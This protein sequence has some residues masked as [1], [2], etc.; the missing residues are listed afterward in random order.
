[1]HTLTLNTIVIF[2]QAKA[3]YFDKSLSSKEKYR[4]WWMILNR[5]NLIKV[6]M[7]Y[8]LRWFH[9]ICQ[10]S[11]VLLSFLY[12]RSPLKFFSWF[13]QYFS[14]F[15]NFMQMGF[16]KYLIFVYRLKWISNKGTILVYK[17]SSIFGP[18]P[19]YQVISDFKLSHCLFKH[20]DN[21]YSISIMGI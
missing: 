15:V 7:W 6:N 10:M 16:R 19:I 17:V 8:I 20:Y 14:C 21:L 1:M 9:V 18:V 3:A 2:Y 12:E 4:E 5:M 11:C 13:E